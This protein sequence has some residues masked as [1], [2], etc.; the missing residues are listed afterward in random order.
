M[1]SS[2]RLSVIPGSLSPW[3]SLRAIVHP[4]LNGLRFAQKRVYAIEGYYATARKGV[5]EAW[6]ECPPKGMGLRWLA[7]MS[8][9]SCIWNVL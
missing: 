9:P 7:S 1:R 8:A 4:R 2:S 5:N 6:G 3:V